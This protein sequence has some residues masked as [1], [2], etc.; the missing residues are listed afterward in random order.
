MQWHFVISARALETTQNYI[1]DLKFACLIQHRHNVLR[2]TSIPWCSTAHSQIIFFA[3]DVVV[4]KK[5][6]GASGEGLTA[7]QID[8]LDRRLLCLCGT[9][10]SLTV[11]KL[12]NPAKDRQATRPPLRL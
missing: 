10:G 4:W 1:P 5:D 12:V 6:L 2:T 8:P 7:I 9:K 11:L 3:V